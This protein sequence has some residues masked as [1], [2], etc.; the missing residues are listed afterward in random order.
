MEP[1]RAARHRGVLFEVWAIGMLTSVVVAGCDAQT[2]MEEAVRQGREDTDRV[3][4]RTPTDPSAD[5]ADCSHWGCLEATTASHEGAEATDPIVV[6]SNLGTTCTSPSGCASGYC[7]DGVCCSV[8]ACWPNDVCHSSTCMVGTEICLEAPIADGSMCNDGDGCTFA[9]S[10]QAGVCTGGGTMACLGDSMCIQ[11]ICV[12]QCNG[13]IG[14]TTDIGTMPVLNVKT[15]DLNGDR[16]ADMIIPNATSNTVSVRFHTG[17]GLTFGPAV[18]YATGPGPARVTLADFNADSYLDILVHTSAGTSMLFNLGDGTFAPRIDG[19]NGVAGNVAD[20]NGDGLL[21]LAQGIGS[22]AY[23]WMNNGDGT[24]ASAVTYNLEPEPANFYAVG[25]LNGDGFAD[26]A[27]VVT[28][29]STLLRVLINNGDGTLKA[30][31]NAG[32]HGLTSDVSSLIAADLDHDGRADLAATDRSGTVKVIL[33]IGKGLT[34]SPRLVGMFSINT[35]G[36]DIAVANLN[37]DGFTDLVAQSSESM[38]AGFVNN[39]NGNFTMKMFSLLSPNRPIVPADLNGDGLSDVMTAG[40]DVYINHGNGNFGHWVTHTAGSNPNRI[41]A[42]DMNDDGFQDMVTANTGN[43][44]VG[45]LL[46]NRDNTFATAVEYPVGAA[47]SSH[48]VGDLNGDGRIDVAVTNQGAN[49]VS[50]LLNVGNGV[51]APKVDYATGDT[52]NSMAAGDMNGDGVADLAVLNQ[53]YN[54]NTV[55]ILLNRGNGRFAP[56]VDYGTGRFPTHLTSG[57]FNGDGLM[58]IAVTNQLDDTLSVLMNNG[59]GTFAPR[60]DYAAG[61]SPNSVSSGDFNEDGFTDLAL[62]SN[63]FRLSVLMNQ[64]NGSFAPQ[65]VYNLG[66]NTRN[67]AVGDL[68]ADSHLDL[69]V[70]YNSIAVLTGGG[71]GTFSLK[72][73]VIS[74]MPYGQ[75]NI[76]AADLNGDGLVDLAKQSGPNE[77]GVYYNTC[78]P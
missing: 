40:R 31:T 72:G 22:N 4:V 16:F 19:A 17:N 27:T 23:V 33:S 15:A 1:S 51:F 45:V 47:A 56:K 24:F 69:A 67:I 12:T 14:S 41:L 28:K 59:N 63:S 55:S 43:S 78:W 54:V 44:R 11:G 37:G 74:D 38:M 70:V 77:I 39:G 25:D 42:A 7:V 29:F 34:F 68:N 35:M 36:G 2:A 58:D 20:F 60:V 66:Y 26:M 49:T 75:S 71:D 65:V 76:I 13:K 52:P 18:D 5:N 46:N 53:G 6:L 48:A 32:P 62:T 10:C 73:H 64:G 3:E 8:G 57:D 50:V 61:D 9:D 21:D 30:P